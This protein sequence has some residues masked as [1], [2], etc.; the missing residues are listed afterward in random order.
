MLCPNP[1]KLCTGCRRF[2][3]RIGRSVATVQ[4]TE[5]VKGYAAATV[6]GVYEAKLSHS[7]ERIYTM[8]RKLIYSAALVA[9]GIAILGI[10]SARGGAGQKGNGAPS[11]PHFDLNLIGKDHAMPQDNSGGD[12]IFV[13]EDGS[14]DIYLSPGDFGVLDDNATDDDGGAFQLPAPSGGSFTYSVWIRAVGKPG[15]NGTITTCATDP[16]TGDVVCSLNSAFTVRNKGKSKFQNVSAD[17]LFITYVND[18]GETVTVPIFDP[19]LEN[20]FWYLDN[21]GQKVIQMRFYQQ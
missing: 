19:S 11:G 9:T 6:V 3:P 14:S 7:E 17:L 10:C 8:K 2:H 16:T 5:Q 15:G 20:Y 21:N 18:L 1:K 4:S 12:V 13:W